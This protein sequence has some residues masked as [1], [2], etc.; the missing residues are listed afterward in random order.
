LTVKQC[1]LYSAIS[2]IRWAADSQIQDKAREVLS[3]FLTLIEV[4]REKLLTG[5]HMAETVR[6][7]VDAV[8]YW[9]YLVAENQ[10][11][12]NAAKWKY[13]NISI[14]TDMMERWEKDPDTINPNI[15]TYLNRITLI[16]RDD[17][18]EDDKGKVNLM[19]IHSA[20]GL[21]FDT[22]FVA[23]VED[24]IIPHG[25]ALEESEDNIEEE[26]RLFYVAITR[27]KRKLYLTSCLTRRMMR[28]LTDCV[29]SR[30]LDEIPVDLIKTHQPDIEASD[31]EAD[32]YFARM[33]SNFKSK[34]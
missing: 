12:E 3:D 28:E 30:F 13:K 14:F 8:D 9:G 19:T 32:E 11:S 5:K 24:A 33:R 20:K 1:S 2:A 29:P 22:V 18:E 27:A 10:K 17:V 16:T 23:G 6:G 21:E 26:R 15:F 31:S 25:R 34:A 7:L 4:Y